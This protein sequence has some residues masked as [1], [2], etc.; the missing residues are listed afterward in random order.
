MP[1][2]RA[3]RPRDP[4]LD[5]RALEAARALLV[6]SGFEATTIQAVAKRSGV[7]SSAIYRRWPSRYELIQDAIFPGFDQPSVAPTGELRAD[8]GRFLDAYLDAFGSPAARA[9]APGL[10]AHQRAG[11]HDRSPDRHLRVSAR[12]Q[13]RAILDAAGPGAVDPAV[14]PDDVFDL[15]LGAILART[16]VPTVAARDAPVERTV[17][18][19]VRLLRPPSGAG[20]A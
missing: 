17:D 20:P 10:L 8:L 15:L 1:A 11:E 9:A 19:L 7:H 12:P 2:A 14:D 16:Q 6:E 5:E 4:S 3:G 18:L 13:F